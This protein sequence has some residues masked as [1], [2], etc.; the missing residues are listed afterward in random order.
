MHWYRK[1]GN[2]FE[3]VALPADNDAIWIIAKYWIA[4]EEKVEFIIIN[5]YEFIVVNC[6]FGCIFHYKRF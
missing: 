1:I 6:D 5:D 2:V 4:S 3:K